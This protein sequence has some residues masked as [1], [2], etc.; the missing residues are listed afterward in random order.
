MPP[1][2]CGPRGPTRPPARYFPSCSCHPLTGLME[3]LDS[4]RLAARYGTTANY[5]AE[6]AEAVTSLQRRG[7]LLP[8]DV[9]LVRP[10]PVDIG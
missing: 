1:V 2:V 7:L 6:F 10:L 5:D 9:A 4:R 3:P 8:D